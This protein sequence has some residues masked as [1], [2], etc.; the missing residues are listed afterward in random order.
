[1]D[2]KAAFKLAENLA[3]ELDTPQMRKL[4]REQKANNNTLDDS[5]NELVEEIND[6][7]KHDTNSLND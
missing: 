6:S 5:V 2:L 1:M 3:K 7:F 4:Y